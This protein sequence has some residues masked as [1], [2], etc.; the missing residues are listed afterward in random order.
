[1]RFTLIAALIV[2]T[3][4]AKEG[5]A[6]KGRY[7]EK[8]LEA[9]ELFKKWD[10]NKNKKVTYE[11][12]QKKYNKMC[13]RMAKR[14]LKD[15]QKSLKSNKR[16][17]ENVL[18]KKGAVICEKEFEEWWPSVPK[19]DP[20]FF[21]KPEIEAFIEANGPVTFNVDMDKYAKEE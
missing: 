5:N 14:S 1:M 11:E 21:T 7:N 13:V 9:D 17:K 4:A 19:E 8:A 6:K 16:D 15:A 3:F 2:T 18:A 20:K 10:V 12:A